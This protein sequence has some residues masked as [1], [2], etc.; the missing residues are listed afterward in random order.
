MTE[1][2]YTCEI[3]TWFNSWCKITSTICNHYEKKI[4]K[5]ETKND[6]S[7][8]GLA[9]H[10]WWHGTTWIICGNT[11]A[12]W[13]VPHGMDHLH[14]SFIHGMR[15]LFERWSFILDRWKQKKSEWRV[16]DPLPTKIK[17]NDGKSEWMMWHKRIGWEWI[18][19][20]RVNDPLRTPK[21]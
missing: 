18:I 4:H 5:L 7:L 14:E 13:T 15:L 2:N 16:N 1:N 21:A 19:G 6:K 17:M 9:A 11:A 3:V 8:R 10:E 12:A 20:V